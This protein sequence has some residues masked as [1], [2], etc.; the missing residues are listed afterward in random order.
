MSCLREEFSECYV[1]NYSSLAG[2]SAFPNCRILTPTKRGQP[3]EQER[4]QRHFLGPF[5]G[6][7]GSFLTC[8]SC[9]FQVMS[10]ICKSICTTFFTILIFEFCTHSSVQFPFF[11]NTIAGFCRS[12]WILNFSIACLFHQ[13]SIMVVPLYVCFVIL[14]IC[15][16]KIFTGLHVHF[17]ITVLLR[18]FPLLWLLLITIDG[19]MHCGGLPE[20]IHCCRT[21]WELLLPQ[22]LAYCCNKVLIFTV[23]KW[24]T[25]MLW[26]ACFYPLIYKS[27][28]CW[29]ACPSIPHFS[30]YYFVPFPDF[31][32]ALPLMLW[33]SGFSDS[34]FLNFSKYL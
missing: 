32:L 8:Q 22:L 12:H 14:V 10:S 34:S 4:W 20:A 30:P 23:W 6:I 26:N 17:D 1:P 18:C 16:F 31:I 28:V 19:W 3:S 7:L 24:G 13:C 15:T 9:S 33:T 27:A 25:S 5:N 11:L 21:S 29:G 2:V